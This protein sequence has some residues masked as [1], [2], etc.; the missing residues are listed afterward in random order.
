MSVA[1]VGDRRAGVG[2]PGSAGGEL[3][4]E[5]DAGYEQARSVWN[6]EI[7]RRPAMVARCRD[8]AEVSAAIRLATEQRLELSVRGGGHNFAGH[9]VCDG[10]LMI[11]LSPMRGVVVDPIS[12]RARCGGGTTWAD[13]D[14]ATQ[15]HG[16]AVP[17][18]IVSHTGVGGLTLGGGIGWL[19]RRAGLSCDNLIAAEVV[20]ANGEVVT[21]S[22]NQR[23]EL[24]WALRGGGGNF[25]VVTTF[26]FGLHEVG[27]IVQLGMFFWHAGQAVEALRF[28]GELVGRLPQRMGVLVAGLS[29]PPAPFVPARYQGQPMHALAIVDWQPSAEHAQVVEEVRAAVPP[30]FDFVTALPYVELQKILDSSAPWGAFAYEKALYIDELSDDVAAV[31]SEFLPKKASPLSLVPMNPL[32]EAYSSHA[33]DDTAFGGR[34]APC[35][36]VTVAA[37]CP[38]R[39]LLDADRDWVRAYWAALRPY[40]NGAG[41]Y[42]NFLADTDAEADSRIRASYG[43][44]KYERLARI[45][46][47]YDPENVFHLNANIRPGASAGH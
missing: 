22:A 23:P 11:D 6:G 18:G 20:L 16:L 46:A 26:E 45:K 28:A 36:S 21:A 33:D 32:A 2:A 39:E 25:G 17:G 40:A 9:A 8:S 10:G 35:W 34:R 24:F 3:L 30:S 38:T 15:A 7:D 31:M 41:S 37:V 19:T 13:L 4:R 27:P 42:I 12:R 29:A 43:S 14:G 1:N 44:V 47:Q 5:G